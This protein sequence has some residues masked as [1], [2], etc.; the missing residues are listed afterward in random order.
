MIGM[1]HELG[2]A[3]VAEGIEDGASYALL[4]EWGCDE[5]Q[6]YFIARPMEPAALIEWIGQ[7]M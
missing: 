3:V 6:G 7:R 4:R 2:H 5:G 1:A